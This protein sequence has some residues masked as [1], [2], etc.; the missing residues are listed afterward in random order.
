MKRLLL[1]LLCLTATLAIGQTT[2]TGLGANTN[3]NT[4]DNWDTNLVPTATD[5]VTIP[6]GFTVTLNVAGTVR[7]IDLQGNS[8]FEMN[9][10]LTFTEPSTFGV[11]TTINWTSGTINGST[12]TL[13][14]LGTINSTTTAFHIISGDTTLDNQGVLNLTSSGDMLIN[15]AGSVLNNPIGGCLLYTSPSP[16][17]KRQSRMPSSA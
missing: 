12:S 1:G 13:T 11:N 3:W 2:W 10:N 16:R 14:N 4:I 17:D 9:T 15:E 7:S 5:D 8:V 6:T